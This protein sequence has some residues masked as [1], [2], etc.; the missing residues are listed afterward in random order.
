MFNATF[1]ILLEY[2]NQYLPSHI[3]QYNLTMVL[4]LYDWYLIHIVSGSISSE[5]LTWCILI[6][7]DILYHIVTHCCYLSSHFKH[8]VP[9]CR[10][11]VSSGNRAFPFNFRRLSFLFLQDQI[12][13]V[14]QKKFFFLSHSMSLLC[15]QFFTHA[16]YR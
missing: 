6:R 11:Y 10:Y 16:I 9:F 2:Q 5:I 4:N 14:C 3:C 8:F 12:S 15:E 13:S 7:I 1:V